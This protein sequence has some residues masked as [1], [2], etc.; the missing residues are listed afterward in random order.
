MTKI[1]IFSLKTLKNK[2]YFNFMKLYGK[3]LLSDNNL[4]YYVEKKR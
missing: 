2:L 1:I 3:W 4:A